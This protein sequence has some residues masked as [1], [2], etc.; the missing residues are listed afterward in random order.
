[1]L[2]RCAHDESLL[3]VRC[4]GTASLGLV[5]DERL[6]SNRDKWMGTVVVLAVHVRIGRNLWVDIGHPL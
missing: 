1:M 2:E 6:Y 3:A 5:V 4:E